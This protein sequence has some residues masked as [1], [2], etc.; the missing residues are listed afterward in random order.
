MHFRVFT[1]QFNN[2]AHSGANHLVRGNVNVRFT[3]INIQPC[4]QA[5]CK[6]IAGFMS[7]LEIKATSILAFYRFK[8]CYTEFVALVNI[9]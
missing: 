6:L 9:A 4:R 1:N 8:F 2:L 7:Q 5:N 3:I